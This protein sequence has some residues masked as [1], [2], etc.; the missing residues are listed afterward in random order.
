[1]LID[2]N[3]A[4]IASYRLAL[5]FYISDFS[6]SKMCICGEDLRGVVAGDTFE[7]NVN[8]NKKAFRDWRKVYLYIPWVWSLS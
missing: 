1:M 2:F 3:S 6:F 7:K 5:I 8:K 4:D